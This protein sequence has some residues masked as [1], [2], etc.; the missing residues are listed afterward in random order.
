MKNFGSIWRK[1]DLHL[2]SPST[3]LNNQFTGKSEDEKWQLY[4]EKLES[5]SDISVLGI[6]DYFSVKGYK[7]LLE[8]KKQGRIPKIDLILPNI[9]LRI[10]PVTE[11]SKSINLHLIISPD[12]VDQLDSLL[13]ANLQFTYAGN[14]YLCTDSELIRFG[15]QF[16]NNPQLEDHIAYNTG[17]EQFKTDIYKLKEIISK[18]E[19]L[20][21]NILIGLANKSTDGNSGIRESSMKATREE[22]YRFSDIIFSS[23]EKDRIYFLG[24]G[25]DSPEKIISLYDSLKPCIHG[26]DAH[27]LDKVCLPDKNRYT[28]IKADPS[29]EGLRQ[30]CFEP[31]G[32][33]KIQELKPIDPPLRI[34]SIEFDFPQDSLIDGTKF[35]YRG[36]HTV[37]FSPNYTCIIGGRGSGKSTLINLMH[38]KMKKNENSF[39]KEHILRDSQN[40]LIDIEKSILTDTSADEK[41]IEFLSQNEI[42]EFAKDYKKLTE[43][44][45]NRIIKNDENDELLNI[46]TTLNIN[47]SKL[48]SEIKN[49]FR[50]LQLKKDLEITKKEYE[51][52]R[53]I[54]ESL[55]SKEYQDISNSIISSANTY[56]QNQQSA[57]IFVTLLSEIQ[58]L[59]NTYRVLEINNYFD[60][61]TDSL[62]KSLQEITD[63][64]DQV[65]LD[66]ESKK[67]GILEK[68]L[69]SEKSKLNEYLKD[70]GLTDENLK[71]ISNAQLNVGRFD[72]LIKKQEEEI[73]DLESKKNILDPQELVNSSVEYTRLL[74][75]KIKPLSNFLENLKT[76]LVKPI[77]LSLEYDYESSE[78]GLF[79]EFEEYFKN[80]IESKGGNMSHI[81]NNLKKADFQN[82]TDR[83]KLVSEITQGKHILNKNES[84]L[85]E[86]LTI[87]E[88]FLVFK[89]LV[90]KY[91]HTPNS[92]KR[93]NV[94]YDNKTLENS[95][96]GQRCTAALVILLSIGNN[97][98]IID[99]PEAHL[100]SLLISNYLVE[101]IKN[102]KKNRQIIFSTHNANFVINGDSDLINILE[103]DEDNK[104]VI[105][106]TTIEHKIMREK[107]VSLEGGESA[108]Y[109]REKKYGIKSVSM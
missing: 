107:L 57:N 5:L 53:K 12:I 66:Q 60:S 13:F 85:S 41:Y 97:P 21:N 84:I 45:F 100:D 25:K 75:E 94:M 17:I 46:E 61:L 14:S 36:K 56:N 87:E 35:C 18:N 78:A 71:D 104:T 28:W 50:L 16:M 29:F 68:I 1:W 79:L 99:E 109:A 72:S 40:N 15:K 62:V 26:S 92:F 93:I 73:A 98:I 24:Q 39:F 19:R 9:E 55:S 49:L 105:S 63:N 83:N 89:T 103:A 76:T 86:I 58:S 101:I 81:R 95:S 4:L 44:I 22:I 3:A 20:E 59:A 96:F 74:N 27:S 64:I 52:N 106:P 33:V 102:T 7:K 108:F 11:I 67:I 10:I 32:R 54:V 48:N 31:E 65:E 80:E 51:S 37:T 82:I 77:S 34:N 69:E 91:N 6:T 88:N 38:R 70:K 47:I 42:E 30:I 2:H 43:A 8:F 23:N 90:H